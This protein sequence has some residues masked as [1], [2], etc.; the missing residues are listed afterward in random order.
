MKG[1]L[2]LLLLAPCLLA[3][4]YYLYADV[5]WDDVEKYKNNPDTIP[6]NHGLRILPALY[7][8][9]DKIATLKLWPASPTVAGSYTNNNFYQSSSENVANCKNIKGTTTDGAGCLVT[10]N[11]DVGYCAG[12]MLAPPEEFAGSDNFHCKNNPPSEHI[13]PFTKDASSVNWPMLDVSDALHIVLPDGTGLPSPHLTDYQAKFGALSKLPS[14]GEVN[15][16][17]SW[18]ASKLTTDFAGIVA[19]S[20]QAYYTALIATDLKV[21]NIVASVTDNRDTW[22]L[23]SVNNFEDRNLDSTM[24]VGQETWMV[25]DMLAYVFS[26]TGWKS[27][28]MQIIHESGYSNNIAKAIRDNLA[29]ELE[30]RESGWVRIA[31]SMRLEKITFWDYYLPE[32]DRSPWSQVTS[33]LDE[34]SKQTRVIV[35]AGKEPFIR[36]MLLELKKRKMGQ[37]SSLDP[38]QQYGLVVIPENGAPCGNQYDN[39]RNPADGNEENV[40]A[41]LEGA[42][43]LCH[44]SHNRATWEFRNPTVMSTDGTDSANK[45]RWKYDPPALN[46]E[47]QY[48]SAEGEES[49]SDNRK[50]NPRTEEIDMTRWNAFETSFRAKAKSQ[51]GYDFP[52]T[53]A[54]SGIAGFT[55]DSLVWAMFTALIKAAKPGLF[56]NEEGEFTLMNLFGDG[57]THGSTTSLAQADLTRIGW[58]GMFG[59]AAAPVADKAGSTDTQTQ[60]ASVLVNE[61]PWHDFINRYTFK[62]NRPFG[63]VPHSIKHFKDGV[64]TRLA[65]MLPHRRRHER[66]ELQYEKKPA[67]LGKDF[68]FDLHENPLDL[69]VPLYEKFKFLRVTEGAGYVMG[70]ESECKYDDSVCAKRRLL[71]WSIP[72]GLILGG[73]FLSAL[74][75]GWI[76]YSRIK[77]KTREVDAMRW[78]IPKPDEVDFM[79]AGMGLRSTIGGGGTQIGTRG[80]TVMRTIATLRTIGTKGTQNTRMSGVSGGSDKMEKLQQYADIAKYRGTRCAV[81]E[82]F[83]NANLMIKESPAHFKEQMKELHTLR[84]PNILRLLGVSFKND[85][86]KWVMLSEYC[87]KGSLMDVLEDRETQLDIEFMLGFVG[88]IILGMEHL[89]QVIGSHGYLKSTNIVVNSQFQIKIADFGMLARTSDAER[90]DEFDPYSK[91]MK[92]M[93][94]A[95]ELLRDEENANI[96]GTKEGDVYS[97]GIICHEIMECSGPFNS[98][99]DSGISAREVISWVAHPKFS[100]PYRPAFSLKPEAGEK[101]VYTRNVVAPNCWEEKPED[102]PTFKYMKM[103][104]L[105]IVKDESISLGESVL[106]RIKTYTRNQEKDIKSLDKLIVTTHD[107]FDDTQQLLLPSEIISKIMTGQQV[108]PRKLD[109]VSVLSLRINGCAEMDKTTKWKFIESCRNSVLELTNQGKD[110]FC[111]SPLADKYV[112]L[113]NGAR[114]SGK[115]HATEL[116][117]LVQRLKDRM[118]DME[119]SVPMVNLQAGIDSGVVHDAIV[120]EQHKRYVMYG[121]TYSISETL[122][123]NA[124]PGMC[125]VTTRSHAHLNS[126]LQFDKLNE[127]S[128]LPGETVLGAYV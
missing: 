7:V 84:H 62:D 86:A 126:N 108:E 97:F 85:I 27:G 69:G 47:T 120:G 56:L 81:T 115:D 21:P 17:I 24:V 22:P 34:V 104:Y 52:A 57:S 74:V 99:D 119:G 12:S 114:R 91:Q 82:L 58:P 88:D 107:S 67:S 103:V 49:Y 15:E 101:E 59:D 66:D 70:V 10:A 106:K 2:F 122:A 14:L 76:T 48:S 90:I 29:E 55:H 77:R 110:M 98:S 54:V 78:M 32:A 60:T 65:G 20:D 41:A 9:A 13:F 96:H 44:N 105:P 33:L 39:Y 94:T 25:I 113:A 46:S 125:L 42:F 80:G 45:L 8:A 89:H 95:P 37:Y 121:D 83:S 102:R 31:D 11:Y 109:N 6:Y 93:W 16:R 64:W 23:S 128:V 100:K 51:F 30:K 3:K 40:K 75:V 61:G 123:R 36:N 79:A 87:N 43:L 4:D 18:I 73:C 72:V 38:D 5:R 71:A 127:L 117:E 68:F 116:V 50:W 1:S 92:K 111:V 112:I 124:K 118:A 19:S 35:L 28:S 63:A 26:E 53:Q